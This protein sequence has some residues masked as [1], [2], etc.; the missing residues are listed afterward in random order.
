MG[1]GI[2][3]QVSRESWR[4]DRTSHRIIHLGRGRYNGVPSKRNFEFC[5]ATAVFLPIVIL[6]A[7]QSGCPHFITI[8]T[9]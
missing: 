2:V 3:G 8:Q 7:I 9:P 5:H 4:L 6:M 1:V